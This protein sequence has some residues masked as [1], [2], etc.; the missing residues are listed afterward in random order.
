METALI[1]TELDIFLQENEGLVRDLLKIKKQ[2]E[3]LDKKDKNI[4]EKLLEAMNEHHIKSFE[5]ATARV[6]Y[7]EDCNFN[8]VNTQKLQKYYPSAYAACVESGYRDGYLVFR[9]K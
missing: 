2:K 3:R 6:Y 5:T 9:K 4:R 1:N 8:R 7:A